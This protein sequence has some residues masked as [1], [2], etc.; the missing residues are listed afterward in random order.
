M[1]RLTIRSFRDS[2]ALFRFPSVSSGP[3]A[4]SVPPFVHLFQSHVPTTVCGHNETI[5]GLG[6]T[7]GAPTEHS[8]TNPQ[9]GGLQ[10]V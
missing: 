10:V 8:R 1:V 9:K 4:Y 5:T 2:N 7:I 6:I 3:L